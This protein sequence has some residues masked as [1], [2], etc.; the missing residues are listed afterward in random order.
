MMQKKGFLNP[1]GTYSL[2]GIAMLMIIISHTYNGYPIDSPSFYFPKWLNVFQLGLWGGMGVCIFFFISGYGMFYTLSKNEHIDREYL[3]SKFKRLFEPFFIYWIVEVIVL[4]IFN[5]SELTIHIFKE[6][7]TF[8]IHPD[9]ENWFFK[10]IVATYIITI[11]LF[12]C[13]LSNGLRILLLSLFAIVYLITMK[14]LDYGQW[15]YN[16]ILAFPA[17]AFVAHRYDWFACQKAWLMSAIGLCVMFA[18]LIFYMNTIVFHLAFILFAIYSIMIVDIQ[19]RILYFIG[20]NSFIF[21]FMECPVM[22]TIMMFAYPHFPFYSLLSVVGTFLLSLLCVKCIYYSN[23]K[24]N[25]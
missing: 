8:S 4:S 9:I 2:R 16:T 5:R 6:I 13:R 10:V 11:A 22:D 7:V 12:K 17:G 23:S 3:L 21:Y 24:A 15:W 14:Q 19:N 25:H 1:K 18:L 20:F